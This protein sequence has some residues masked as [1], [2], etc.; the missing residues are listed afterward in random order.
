[1]NLEPG[2]IEQVDGSKFTLYSD[3]DSS[4]SLVPLPFDKFIDQ[5]KT[6]DY[7]QNIAKELNAAYLALFNET[8]VKY[9]NVNPKYNFMDFKSEVV[10]YRGFFN[11]KKYYGLTKLWDEGTFY[12]PPVVKKTGGQIVKADSTPIVLDLLTEVYNVL[13]LDFSITDEVE[14]YHK[15]YFEIREKYIKRV[16]EAVK[17]FDVH[18]FG[19]PKKWSLKKL[20][21]IPK[22]VEGA[23]LYNYLFRDI[24]RPGESILQTQIIVNPGKLLQEMDKKSPSTEYQIPKELISNK[25]NALSFPTEFGNSKKDIEEA[26]KIFQENN[27]QFDLRTILEFNVEKKLDQ[28]K[29]LF[30]EETI[31]MAI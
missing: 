28:F 30:S 9:G 3:T 10:A 6:V 11:A 20:K 21:K 23:M 14:L 27:I 4:Y 19:I 5:H 29:K 12:D 31:R 8:V 25:I 18:Q 22:Q 1:M 26:R 16:E 13:L 7:A 2:F 17:N 24:F 15:I